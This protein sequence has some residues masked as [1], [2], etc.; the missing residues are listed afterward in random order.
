MDLAVRD[1]NIDI[2]RQVLEERKQFLVDKHRE[3][4][5]VSEENKLLIDVAEDY[6]KYHYIIKKQK[7]EQCAALEL[8]SR[9]ISDTAGTL[10]QTEEVLAQSKL[11]QQQIQSQISRLREDIENLL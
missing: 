1:R 2:L 8:I 9:Y 11:Q 5:K 6:S 3:I 4:R 7:M 10:E